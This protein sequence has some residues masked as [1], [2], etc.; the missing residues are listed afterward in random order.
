MNQYQT[1]LE[2][3]HSQPS[4]N[5][6]KSPLPEQSNEK[7]NRTSVTNITQAHDVVPTN[8]NEVKPSIT[9]E[10]TLLNQLPSSYQASEIFTFNEHSKEKKEAFEPIKRLSSDSSLI[11]Q[12]KTMDLSEDQ[13][14]KGIELFFSLWVDAFTIISATSRKHSHLHNASLL[15][16]Y[17]H[18]S[19]YVNRPSKNTIQYFN[20]EF[21]F[22]QSTLD[23]IRNDEIVEKSFYMPITTL[24]RLRLSEA[25]D[26]CVVNNNRK[27]ILILDK[28]FFIT[29]YSNE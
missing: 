6:D 28:V 21:D 10:N 23:T 18:E 19:Q 8:Q 15:Y 29:K 14:L 13:E 4:T 16:E 24:L 12:T 26:A 9:I 7:K 27:F 17:G 1:L 22:S 2:R 5:E 20:P 3:L 25:L 11:P